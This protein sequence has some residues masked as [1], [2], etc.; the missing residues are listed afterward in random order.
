MTSRPAEASLPLLEIE[1]LTCRYGD[2]LALD[3]V[4][5]TLDVGEILGVTGAPGAGMSTLIKAIMMLV[6]PQDGIVLI[7]GNPHNLASSRAHIAHLPEDIRPPGH[8]SGFDFISMT[9]TVQATED[10]DGDLAG[11]AADLAFDT[12]LLGHPIRRY[13]QEDVQKLGLIA[14]FLSRRPIL[15]LDR[16]MCDLEPAAR[17]G[18]RH[19]LKQHTVSGGAVLIGS[20]AIEDHQD[21]VD[22]LVILKDGQLQKAD[23]IEI[24]GSTNAAA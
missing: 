2:F 11:L 10:D 18:L 9:S 16:P 22:R 17:A 21:V 8:L 13:T 23:A 6:A 1:A 12:K 24:L 4:S 20:H 7:K 5:M 3:S 14:V 15:L 19:R